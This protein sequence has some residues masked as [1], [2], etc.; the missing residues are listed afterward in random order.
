MTRNVLTGRLVTAREFLCFVLGKRRRLKV[1][2]NSM[3]PTAR[4]G[5]YVLVDPAAYDTGLPA[6]GELVVATHPHG[7]DTIIKR[8]AAVAGAKVWLSADNAT[9]GQDSRHFGAIDRAL[10][11]GKVTAIIA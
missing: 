8:V 5:D 10:L 11:R 7:R 6:A 2:N 9:A 1:V 4:G 3:L